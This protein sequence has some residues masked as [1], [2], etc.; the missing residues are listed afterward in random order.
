MT[1]PSKPRTWRRWAFKDIYGAYSVCSE[2]YTRKAA[3]ANRADN[4][5]VVRVTITERWYVAKTITFF[6]LRRFVDA[7][8]V[9]CGKSFA[10]HYK[11]D[12]GEQKCSTKET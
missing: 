10:V 2:G 3:Y 5:E 6:S 7:W 12:E 8:R 11:A 1:K 4:E 9:L